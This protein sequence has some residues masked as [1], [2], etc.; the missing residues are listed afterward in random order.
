MKDSLITPADLARIDR[1]ELS[2]PNPDISWLCQIARRLARLKPTEAVFPAYSALINQNIPAAYPIRRDVVIPLEEHELH[3]VGGPSP[4]ILLERTLSCEVSDAFLVVRPYVKL[5]S[6]ESEGT[7]EQLA[8]LGKITVRADKAVLTEGPLAE[9][10]V[11]FDSYGFHRKPFAF[12]AGSRPAKWVFGVGTL[13]E[14]K[15]VS[16]GELGVFLADKTTVTVELSYP[17]HAGEELKLA[18]G[19][20][21]ARYTTKDCQY[22]PAPIKVNA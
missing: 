15:T 10:L 21:M 11:G 22:W 14:D 1:L 17:L 5:V 9:H 16:P 13:N 4:V 6:P 8:R 18:T 7:L 2:Q 12:T 20:V 3:W 19:L